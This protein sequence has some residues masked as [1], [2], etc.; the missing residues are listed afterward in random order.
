MPLSC[1]Y[2][3]ALISICARCNIRSAN[4]PPPAHVITEA[5]L[6][7]AALQGAPDG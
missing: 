4:S 7:G 2:E 3:S 1:T 6:A 5:L